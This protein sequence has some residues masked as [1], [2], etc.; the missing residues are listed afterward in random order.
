[1]PFAPLLQPL[2]PMAIL[3][4]ASTCLLHP[5][6]NLFA[7]GFV[8]PPRLL[9]VFSVTLA[10]ALAAWGMRAVTF[11]GAFAG[12]LVTGLMCLAAGLPAIFTIFTVFLLTFISTR[13]GYSRKL[14][15]GAAEHHEGRH[16]SQIYANLGAAALCAAPLLLFP[17]IRG[18][19]LG[20]TAALAEAAADTVSSELGQAFSHR[21][22]LITSFEPVLP[23]TNGGVSAI[24][25]ATGIAAA[26]IVAAIAVWTGLIYPHWFWL[27][28]AG[29]TIG[30][31]FDSLLG[32]T[33]EHPDGLGNDSVNFVS[34]SFAATFVL[35]TWLFIQVRAR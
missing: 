23:G 18:L 12:F 13:L 35:L 15:L 20:T 4:L 5:W 21:P 28:V 27:I 7:L 10:F 11:S 16:A 3:A 26:C 2:R 9:P 22:L 34:T 1:M 24:G 30:M 19:L 14:K 25:T 32:A 8:E 6:S 31:F 29:A 33:V 17:S